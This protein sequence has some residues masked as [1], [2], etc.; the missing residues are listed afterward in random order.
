MSTGSPQ[1][2]PATRCPQALRAVRSGRASCVDLQDALPTGAETE[3]TAADCEADPAAR[4]TWRLHWLSRWLVQHTRLPCPT[5]RPR[6]TDC[7]GERLTQGA[8]AK[9]ISLPSCFSLSHSK[10]DRDRAEPGAPPSTGRSAFHATTPTRSSAGA[11]QRRWLCQEACKRRRR[12]PRAARETRESPHSSRHTPR[13]GRSGSSHGSPNCQA[14][15]AEQ[16]PV[17]ALV[18]RNPPTLNG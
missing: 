5:D 12:G 9:A 10:A 17:L 15:R 14:H 6:A 13:P 2:Q 1:G 7:T 16:G 3:A 4:S 18:S 11:A 8:P